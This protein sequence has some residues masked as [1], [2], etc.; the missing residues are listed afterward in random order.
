AALAEK[1]ASGRTVVLPGLAEHGDVSDWIADGGTVEQLEALVA[2][3]PPWPA[4]QA[5]VTAPS[6]PAAAP[7][8]TSQS[9]ATLLDDVEA[10]LRRYVVFSRRAQ[11]VACA[12]WLAHAH[13]IAAAEITPYLALLSPEKRCGKSRLLELLEVL[14]PHAWLVARTTEAAL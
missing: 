7:P 3:T 6:V 1:V 13:I 8:M 5:A 9:L 2:E 4:A 11:S 10:F 14:A 12:L